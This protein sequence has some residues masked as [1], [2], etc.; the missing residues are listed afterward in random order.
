MMSALNGSFR[1]ANKN[2]RLTSSHVINDADVGLSPEAW[3]CVC[4]G[5]VA[6]HQI[7]QGRAR[8][9]DLPAAPGGRTLV[10]VVDKYTNAC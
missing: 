9:R 3:K 4:R 8:A 2:E 7:Q 10:C 6:N 1:L 5:G